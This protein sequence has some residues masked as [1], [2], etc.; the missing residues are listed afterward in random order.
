MYV[1]TTWKARPLSPEQGQRMMQVWAKTEAKQAEDRSS[2]RVCF[3]VAADGSG[4]LT[5]SKVADPDAAAA[6]FLELSLA[7]GEFIELDS[8]IALDMDAAMPA[9]IAAMS[10]HQ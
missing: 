4:G 10:Y 8:K 2:E 9:I 3:F 1:Y 7:L 6:S 5:V